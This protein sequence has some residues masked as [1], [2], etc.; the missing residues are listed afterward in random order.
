M[1][2]TFKKL[3]CLIIVTMI[4]CGFSLVFSSHENNTA[5]LETAYAQETTSPAEPQRTMDQFKVS[6]YL[7]IEGGQTYLEEDKL[8]T[9]GVAYFIIKTIELLTKIIGSFALL[10]VILGGMILMLSSGNED[11]QRRGKEI[12]KYALIGLV[13]AF[14]SLLVVTFVQSLFFTL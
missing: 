4:S 14:T 3:I 1:R 13:I 11:F 8:Q 5:F 10:F 6:D 2:G 7:K 12:I 9:Q